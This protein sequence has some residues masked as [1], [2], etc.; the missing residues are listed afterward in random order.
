M[1]AISICSPAIIHHNAVFYRAMGYNKTFEKFGYG[2]MNLTG[3]QRDPN[4]FPWSGHVNKQKS[5]LGLSKEF[6]QRKS[7]QRLK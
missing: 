1:F 7:P 3:K 5:G 2:S 4:N 6:W